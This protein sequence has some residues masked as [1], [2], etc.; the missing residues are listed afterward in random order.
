MPDLTDD[1]LLEELEIDLEPSKEQE[2]TPKQERI[3]A[4]F[5]DIQRFVDEHGRRPQHGEDNDIFERLYA[6]RLDRIL[7][8]DEMK[9]LLASFD[10]QGLLQAQ[11][12]PST[13]AALGDDDLLEELGV[14]LTEKKN[15]A[16]LKHV[17]SREDR[18]AA[19]EIA[20]RVPCPDFDLFR[21]LFERAEAELESGLRQS[22]RFAGNIDIAKG[23]FFILGG[24][25]A[26]VAEKG[27]PFLTSSKEPDARL[28][29]IYSNGLESNLLLRSLQK[30]LY[31]DEAGRRLITPANPSLF[32]ESWE[33]DDVSSGTIYILR[34]HSSHPF[35][36]ANRTLVHKIGVTGSSV[37]SRISNARNEA[38]YLL[39]DVEVVAT[40]KMSGIQRSK[41]EH[42]LHRVFAPAKIDLEIPDRF[43]I[44]VKPEE[45]FLVPLSVVDEAIHKIRDG[46]IA[47]FDYDPQQA[48]LVLRQD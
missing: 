46:S 12:D 39:A 5:E 29:L 33:E 1:Q 13:T 18:R 20:N 19:E 9:E 15:V 4:G 43:G 6:V 34:S 41:L 27:E 42:L 44:V 37:E 22:K 17:A 48:R 28:R 40:Y 23:E 21:P 47:N 11:D 30:A 16:V 7:A 10:Y 24:Q 2:Y 32:G 36:A 45:W 3:I 35:I 26:Y 8:E 38:T 31:K 14:T 25:L